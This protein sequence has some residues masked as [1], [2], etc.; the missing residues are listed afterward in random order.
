MVVA[1]RELDLELDTREE[2]RRGPEDERVPARLEIGG[3][4]GDPSV[5]VRLSPGDDVTLT[6]ELHPDTARGTACGGVE[7]VRRERDAH[8]ANL[9]A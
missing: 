2:R 8:W 4:L 9:R 6:D 7:H 1:L 3:E 5:R